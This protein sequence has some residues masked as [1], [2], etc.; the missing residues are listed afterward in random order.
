MSKHPR[1]IGQCY[2]LPIKEKQ[3]GNPIQPGCEQSFQDRNHLEMSQILSG[4]CQSKCQWY[5]AY[6]MANNPCSVTLC[7][8]IFQIIMLGQHLLKVSFG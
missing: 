4:V 8:S 7:Y 1:E 5:E 6:I 3:S 2:Y